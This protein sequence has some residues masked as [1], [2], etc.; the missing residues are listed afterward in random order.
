[1][2]IDFITIFTDDTEKSTNFYTNILGFKFDN[3]IKLPNNLLLTFLKDDGGLT[4]ELVNSGEPVEK[5]TKS[6]V[7]LTIELEDISTAL[8]I[9]KKADYPIELEPIILPTGMKMMH[10]LDPNGVIINFIQ[11]S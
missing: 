4:V 8:E 5:P 2:K 11:M 10:I 3:Q 7:A 6:P 9:V 1:M